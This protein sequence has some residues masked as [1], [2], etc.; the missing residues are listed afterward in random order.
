MLAIQCLLALLALILA[1]CRPAT[2]PPAALDTTV[3]F[4]DTALAELP[5]TPS[6]RIGMNT[7][8]TGTGAQIGDLSVRAARLA[9]EEIN[10]AGGVDGV[11]IELVVRDCRSNPAV[12]VQQYREALFSDDLV[13]LLGPFKSAY[14]VEVVPLHRHDSIPMLIGATK[15]TLTEL[16]DAN[17]F[18]MR[19]SDR[20]TAA[21]M[22]AV[23]VERLG[24]RRIAVVHDADPFGAGGAQDIGAHLAD[25]KVALVARLAY[26]TGTRDFAP[27]VRSLS[28]AGPDAI[29]VYGTNNTDVGLLLRAIRFEGLRATIITSPSGATPVTHNIAAEAQD[30][31]F[32]VTDTFL[33]AT[34]KGRRFEE[35]FAAR[36]GVPPDTYVAW[37][38]DAIYML[39]AALREHGADPQALSRAL[40][41]TSY[42]GAQGTYRF[43]ERG[44][45]LHQVAV[46]QMSGGKPRLV[47][48]YVAA[49]FV[50]GGE[51]LRGG[52]RP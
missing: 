35:V 5:D 22:T 1:A 10:A 7:E 36:F 25:R 51:G 24:L 40:R 39:A 48:T 34:Q 29:L 45:G 50:R 14:A 16:G 42:E 46:V 9:V 49:G 19:P 32:V 33:G 18:R 37:Y 28:A 31:I 44:D 21:A 4:T 15:A 41:A 43:D 12:A 23:A 3:A 20:L 8:V 38:Y 26:R 30:G 2:Q 47:D 27:L 17:L 13:A 6:Y 11:P 52:L